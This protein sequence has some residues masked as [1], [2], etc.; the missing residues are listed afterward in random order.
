MVSQGTQHRNESWRYNPTL[1][2]VVKADKLAKEDVVI[3][4]GKLVLAMHS[5]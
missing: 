3:L 1:Q 2:N 4:Q 5:F